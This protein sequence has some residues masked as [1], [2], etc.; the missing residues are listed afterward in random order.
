[1]AKKL[2]SLLIVQSSLLCLY[3]ETPQVIGYFPDWGQWNSPAYNW[4][5]ID[6][7]AVSHVA[8]AFLYPDSEGNLI[9][10]DTAENSGPLDSLISR[11]HENGVKVILS[12]GGSDGSSAFAPMASS[13]TARARFTHQL[14]AF[15]VER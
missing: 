12:L 4:D 9:G 7:A 13:S 3:A 6:F 10:L 15:L 11:A 2:F 5:D 1:M 14:K 8:W